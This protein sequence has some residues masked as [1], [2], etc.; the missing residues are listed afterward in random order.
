MKRKRVLWTAPIYT[1]DFL[2]L[3]SDM[4]D[5]GLLFLPDRSKP[6]GYMWLVVD[7]ELRRK[8][9]GEKWDLTPHQMR[10][11]IAW[12]LENDTRLIEWE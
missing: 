11:F 7:Y 4:A 8:V 12:L 2:K 6:N 5:D 1:K 9:G 10:R 3:A